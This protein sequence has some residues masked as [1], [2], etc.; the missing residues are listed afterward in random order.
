VG[1][2]EERKDITLNEMM[3]RSSPSGLSSSATAR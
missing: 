2:I 3:A 1:L